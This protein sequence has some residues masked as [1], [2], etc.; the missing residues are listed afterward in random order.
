MGFTF[1]LETADGVPADPPT[2]QTVAP[3]PRDGVEENQ[4]AA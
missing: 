4:A 1:R 2:F 3:M